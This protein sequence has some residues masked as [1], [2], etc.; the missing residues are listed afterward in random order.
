MI[1]TKNQFVIGSVEVSDIDSGFRRGDDEVAQALYRLSQLN[2][3]SPAELVRET[4]QE[5]AYVRGSILSN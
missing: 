4:D 3:I 1:P 5:L 2:T